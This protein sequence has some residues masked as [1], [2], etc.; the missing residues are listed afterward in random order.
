MSLTTRATNKPMS[1]DD[2]F[3]MTLISL[4]EVA[5]NILTDKAKGN[6]KRLYWLERLDK[7][8]NSLDSTYEGY[9]PDDFVNKS[10]KFHKWVEIDMNSLLDSYRGSK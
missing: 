3:Q 9:L 7:V 2:T 1:P 8:I 4:I 10:M 5:K 6:T